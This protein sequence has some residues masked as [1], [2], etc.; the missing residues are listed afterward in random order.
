MVGHIV[1]VEIE[2]DYNVGG[3]L[4]GDGEIGLD[5]SSI[6]IR[7]VSPTRIVSVEIWIIPFPWLKGIHHINLLIIAFIM[8]ITIQRTHIC[9]MTK[10]TT[11]VAYLI[12]WLLP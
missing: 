3:G 11:S 6:K 2:G 4:V 10:T 1:V 8:L 7:I 5:C 12:P 9:T